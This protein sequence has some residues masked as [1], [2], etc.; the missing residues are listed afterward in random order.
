VI[1]FREL[2]RTLKTL[3]IPGRNRELLPAC[4]AGWKRTARANRERTETPAHARP[5][6]WLFGRFHGYEAH[7]RGMWEWE[8][9]AQEPLA[10]ILPARYRS[11]HVGPGPPNWE[12]LGWRRVQ[13]PPG[14]GRQGPKWVAQ[15]GPEAGLSNLSPH[16]FRCW[17]LLLKT[18]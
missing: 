7:W 14:G 15:V 6:P 18:C 17:T 8:N 1:Q 2:L 16:S 5:D 13:R 3:T 10:P 9:E 12:G 11:P 4:R